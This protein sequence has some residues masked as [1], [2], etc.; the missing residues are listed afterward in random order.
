MALTSTTRRR[1]GG[2]R[3]AGLVVAVALVAAAC[4]GD[5]G[6]G[7]T[8]AGEQ[9]TGGAG[10]LPSQEFV[11]EDGTTTT[12]EGVLDGKPLVV[13]FF[14]SWCAPCRAEMP[15][16]QA[17]Y[18]DVG[19]E[20]DFI[21]LAQNDTHDAAADLVDLTGVGYP[22][23]LDENGTVYASFGLVQMPAT[24]YISADGEVLASDGGQIS[25]DHLR[26]RLSEVF[27]VSS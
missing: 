25:E 13:N 24:Y 15:D 4:G 3:L 6:D 2:V 8:T 5:D 22:W 26:D 1:L 20:V 12:V 17:V 11:L 18:T 27:G 10:D 9:E 16:L 23:G 14:A 21:G 19:E 7:T